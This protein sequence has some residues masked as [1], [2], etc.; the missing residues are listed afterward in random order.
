MGTKVGFLIS[1]CKVGCRMSPSGH[2]V[3]RDWNIC[4]LLLQGCSMGTKA[5][6]LYNRGKWDAECRRRGA[7]LA[8]TGTSAAP[9]P[10]P[11]V[12]TRMRKVSGAVAGQ[13]WQLQAMPHSHDRCA[14]Q[15]ADGCA[16]LRKPYKR[17]PG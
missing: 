11:A 3:S 5:G 8:A 1:L 4:H 10:P 15:V 7:P 16:L 17:P 6:L 9:A 14:K 12:G 2:A 13:P